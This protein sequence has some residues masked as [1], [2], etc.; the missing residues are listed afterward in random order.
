MGSASE[1]GTYKRVN[2]RSRFLCARMMRL[3]LKSCLRDCATRGGEEEDH[4][5]KRSN[6]LQFHGDCL[7][8]RRR[9]FLF[10]RDLAGWKCW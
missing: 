5:K 2:A 1:K 7:L 4:T 8:E 10:N 9:M 3:S 6:T